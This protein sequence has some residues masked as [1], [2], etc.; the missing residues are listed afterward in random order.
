[1]RRSPFPVLP[2][3]PPLSG[4]LAEAAKERVVRIT[5]EPGSLRHHVRRRAF[6]RVQLAG[7][8]MVTTAIFWSI[9]HPWRAAGDGTEGR[10]TRGLTTATIDTP[11][12]PHATDP[13]LAGDETRIRSYATMLTYT[14]RGAHRGVGIW[15]HPI[16]F[17]LNLPEHYPTDVANEVRAAYRWMS[18]VTGL[19]I[20]ETTGPDADINVTG[21]PDSGGLTVL[22]DRRDHSLDRVDVHIGCCRRRVVWEEALHSMGFSSDLGPA[23]SLVARY[24]LRTAPQ[25]VPSPADTQVLRALYSGM[26][27]PGAR[28]DEVL[29]ALAWMTG[30]RPQ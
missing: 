22:H 29:T 27:N 19:Q 9:T 11:P 30:G 7:L 6:D 2:H 20:Q 15:T 3:P 8:V 28:M 21:H 12:D 23:G 5:V 17:R 1:M 26:L 13:T 16:T 10:S 18:T 14:N 25:D 24:E 4:R